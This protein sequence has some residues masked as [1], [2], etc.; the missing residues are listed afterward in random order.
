MTKNQEQQIVNDFR[1]GLSMIG[2]ARKHKLTVPQVEQVIRR[3][4]P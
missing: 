2:L 3:A 1:R 4:M